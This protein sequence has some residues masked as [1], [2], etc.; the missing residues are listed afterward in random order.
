MLLLQ[1]EPPTTLVTA[2]SVTVDVAGAE[3]NV[4]AAVARFGGRAALLTRLGD[5]LAGGRVLGEMD[6]LGISADLVELD[7]ERPTGLFLRETPPDGSRQVAYYR[8]GSAASAMTSFDAV[9][10]WSGACPRAVVLSG[11]TAALGPGPRDLIES[12]AVQAHERGV[13]VV[14]DVNLRP[15]LGQAEAAVETL[16]RILPRTDLLVLGD[17]E[18]GAL[19]G[20]TDPTGVF[21]AAANAGVRET[22][23][24]GGPRGSWYPGEDGSPHH[25]PTRAAAVVDPIGAGDA[26]LG[27]YLG[28]RLAGA[29]AG[30]AAWLGSELAAAVISAP[31]DTAGLPSRA[32]ATALLRRAG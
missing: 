22:I 27:G 20:A 15:H 23:L 25:C 16:R 13:A 7:H 21:A 8:R 19:L 4:G 5:D 14:V 1:A 32:E 17:D 30:G 3:Y 11:I 26:F 12:I 18:S 6:R 31:G 29:S 24:K 10:L 28:G 2:T 9:R